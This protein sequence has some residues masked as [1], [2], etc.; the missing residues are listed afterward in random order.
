MRI[1]ISARGIDFIKG[2]ETLE[3]EACPDSNNTW[4]I[5]YGHRGVKRGD[6]CTRG[7]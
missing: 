4:T 1:P 5:G 7:A 3:L 6:T 2:F